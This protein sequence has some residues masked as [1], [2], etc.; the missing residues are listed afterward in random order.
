MLTENQIQ[1][2]PEVFL[3]L[4]TEHCQMQVH[5]NKRKT[6]AERREEKT[7]SDAPS[8]GKKDFENAMFSRPDVTL[9]T[10]SSSIPAN[11]SICFCSIGNI[12]TSILLKI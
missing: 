2:C 6:G 3:F 10:T 7:G 12:L 8:D 9:A 5:Q 11:V 4:V 1:T